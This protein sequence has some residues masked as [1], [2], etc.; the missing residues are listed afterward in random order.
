MKYTIGDEREMSL[1]FNNWHPHSPVEDSSGERFI[2]DSS[3]GKNAM[4]SVLVSNS[5][6]RRGLKLFGWIHQ[7]RGS[8]SK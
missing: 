1:W 5:E 2:Y 6:W 3:M 7:I 4:V 8:W